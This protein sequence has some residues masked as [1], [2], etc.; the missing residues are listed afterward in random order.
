MNEPLPT[1]EELLP[2]MIQAV[3][4]Y[5]TGTFTDL[6]NTMCLTIERPTDYHSFWVNF[7]Y[8]WVSYSFRITPDQ[9]EGVV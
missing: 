3:K 7:N 6:D 5:G 9:L 1:H 2:H 8:K 4:D